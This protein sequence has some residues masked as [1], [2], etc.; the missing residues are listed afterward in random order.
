MTIYLDAVS[1]T[2]KTKSMKL[3]SKFINKLTVPIAVSMISLIT[4]FTTFSACKESRRDWVLK[5]DIKIEGIAPIGLTADGENFWLSDG[6]HN[7]LVK[8]DKN[9]KHINEEKDFERPMHIAAEGNKIFIPTYGTDEILILENGV[10]TKL[11]LT[12][13]LDAPAGVDIWKDQIA[14]ADF[15]NH[16]ILFFNGTDW[17]SIGKKGKTDGLFDYPTDVQITES[18]IYIADAYNNRIQIF[19]KTGKHLLAFGKE[20]KMNA[21]TGIFVSDGE[22]FSTDFENDRVLIFDLDGNLKQELD[23]ENGFSKPTDLIVADNVLYVVN[24]KGQHISVLERK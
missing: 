3:K 2:E 8:I 16:R 10:R 15:Y 12:E 5:S 11:E 14:I 23:K 22:I 20:H 13:E 19:D 6:D 9:G 18:K 21:T 17:I 7:R 24:Y 1:T 4:F